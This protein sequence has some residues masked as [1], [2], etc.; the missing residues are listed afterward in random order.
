MSRHRFTPARLSL[1]LAIVALGLAASGG[2]QATPLAVAPTHAWTFDEGYGA[3][4]ASDSGSVGGLNG[5]GGAD[6][7]WVTG[8]APALG[9]A[10]DRVV[11]MFPQAG[12]NDPSAFVDFGSAPGAFQQSD[13]TVSHFFVTSHNAS[14]TLSDVIG[15]RTSFGHGNFFAVRMR[16][17]GILS[18][19]IDQDAAGT[20]YVGLLAEGHPVNDSRLHHL[21]YV[22]QGATLSL[23]IDGALVKAGQT[24]S[25][26]P[27]VITGADSFRIG[28]RAPFAFTSLAAFYDD[29]RVYDRGLSADEV[30]TLA[31]GG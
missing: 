28:R 9:P 3:H 24:A 13:F 1:S 22:R 4:V 15:N 17:D 30:R 7:L 5:A 11:F 26:R 25:G 31:N 23:Y 29:L 21:A 18:V 2:A 10:R 6:A 14:G 27:T 12:A 8:E 20:S 16:G 19:E